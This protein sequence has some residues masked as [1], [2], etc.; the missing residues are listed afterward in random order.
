[1][2][3]KW[4]NYMS[5]SKI[6]A[7]DPGKNGGIAVFSVDKDTLIDV[8]PMPDTPQDVLNFIT[9][10][11]NNSKCY[12]ERVQGIPGMG[13]TAMFNFGQ[14]FG[15]LEMALLC[16]HIPT[17]EVTPQKWQRELQLGVKGH[18]TTNEWKT[19]LKM[20]A[21]QLY[22]RVEQQFN[23]KNKTEWL[24]VSDALLILEYARRQ[25]IK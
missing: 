20:R 22:P 4:T 16:R 17:I 21:Q 13:A 12:L 2:N 23:I 19:K 5:D 10:Y 8:A 3:N 25:E 14:G 9:H 15:Q 18:N 11:Q 24:R 1:M 7:I 6:I